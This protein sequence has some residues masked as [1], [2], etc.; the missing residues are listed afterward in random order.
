MMDEFVEAMGRVAVGEG[1]KGIP[2]ATG[3]GV[4]RDSMVGVACRYSLS[5]GQ[6]EQFT[7][8]R[9]SSMLAA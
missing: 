7:G 3:R 5:D 1:W 8:G 4:E 6:I 2:A 9:G